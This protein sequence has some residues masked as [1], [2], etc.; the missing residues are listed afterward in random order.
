MKDW[1]KDLNNLSQDVKEIS[2]YFAQ[3]KDEA[4]TEFS[5]KVENISEI[6]MSMINQSEKMNELGINVP[7]DIII[8][9]LENIVEGLDKKD[10]ILLA[11]T[12]EYEILPSLK[13]YQEILAEIE[14]Q[15]PSY[16]E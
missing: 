2:L 6:M 13:F 16:L 12:L 3:D 7:K 14:K 9:Q 11:D 1:R 15:N 8:M 5:K 4:Y 10:S